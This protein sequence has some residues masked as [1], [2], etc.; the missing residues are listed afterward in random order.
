MFGYAGSID[1]SMKRSIEPR[2]VPPLVLTSN[3]LSYAASGQFSAAPKYGLA[4]ALRAERAEQ[5]AAAVK[6]Q[7]VHRGRA[8]RKQ[9]SAQREGGAVQ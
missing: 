2:T 3:V 7:A 6:I 5:E 8:A 1:F 9:I 4:A